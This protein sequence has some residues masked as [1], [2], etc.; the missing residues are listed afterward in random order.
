MAF[1][2]YFGLGTPLARLVKISHMHSVVILELTGIYN[3][4]S[5]YRCI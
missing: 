4:Q 5:K 2:R 1:L 3:V